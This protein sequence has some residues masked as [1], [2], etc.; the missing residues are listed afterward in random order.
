MDPRIQQHPR[1][2]AVSSVAIDPKIRLDV[3]RQ[4]LSSHHVACVMCTQNEAHHESHNGLEN[5]SEKIL[6]EAHC[7]PY[8]LVG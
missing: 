8:I 5:R 2:Q 7:V 6:M 4:L 3:S 1:H